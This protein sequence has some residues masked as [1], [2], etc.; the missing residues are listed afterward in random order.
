MR[1]VTLKQAVACEFDTEVLSFREP[2][3]V[4]HEPQKQLLLLREGHS[5][6]SAFLMDQSVNAG[7]L[8][9]LASWR[10]QSRT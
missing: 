1:P 8:A 3:D 2:W 4:V 9:T 7:T 10:R 6:T 5:T